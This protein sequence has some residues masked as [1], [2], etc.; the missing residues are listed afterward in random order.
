[1]LKNKH[2]VLAVVLLAAAAVPC[3][4][5]EAKLLAVLKSSSAT[6]AEKADACRQLVR[7][8]TKQ[9]VPVLASLLGD[10]KLSHMARYALE[11]I[12]DPSVDEALRG[13]WANSR[14]GH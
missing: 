12:R 9:S 13:P 6:Q 8:A 2:I 11:P 3:V 10:E 7:V 1:M 4:A 14:A 5:Q